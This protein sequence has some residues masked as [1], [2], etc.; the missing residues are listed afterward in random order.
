MRWAFVVALAIFTLAAGVISCGDDSETAKDT[1]ASLNNFPAGITVEKQFTSGEFKNPEVCGGCHSEIFDQWQGSMHNNS[2]TD[3]LYL[4]LHKQAGEDTG[5]ATDT[6]CSA[7]H[8]P[9][10]VFSGEVP[11]VTGDQV[12]EIARQGVQCD[13]CHTVTGATGVGNYAFTFAPS[14]VKRGP[15][16]DAVSS[17]HETAYSELHTRSEFCGT[18]HDVN[19]PGNGVPLEATYTEWKESPYAADGVQCQDCHMTPG[20]GVTK[21]NPGRAAPEGPDRPHIFTHDFVGGNAALADEKHSKLAVAQLQAAAGLAIEA[22]AT[23]AAGEDASFRVAVTNK[24]AGHY[25]P[26][27][28]TEVREMWLDVE[29][30]DANGASVF[31][32]GAVGDDGAVDEGAVMYHTVLEDKNGDPTHKPW[33][34]AGI[35]SDHR[36]PPL[37][38]VNEDYIAP[39]P[40]DAVL[41]LTIKVTLRYRS[42]PQTVVDELLG[43]SA[44]TLPI[45]DMASVSA[46]VS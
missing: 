3:P 33:F 9:I 35:L 28:L 21:P 45:I 5:G 41:P 25:L 13:F 7:C 10:G 16:D 15:F 46:A 27:G 23:V 44:P 1:E 34:A 29:I 37:E 40:A 38:T 4:A 18:C 20:P 24:G 39:I 8:S 11:P 30:T 17:Y 31:R 22:P 14:N 12:S 32:S 36:I 2:F 6:F 43:D 42:A 26:T 19:H